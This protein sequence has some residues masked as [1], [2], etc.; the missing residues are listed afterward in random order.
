MEQYVMGIDI[1]TTGAKSMVVALDGKILGAGYCEYPLSYPEPNAV[2][3]SADHMMDKVY[4]TVKDAIKNSGV[5]SARIVAISFSV[6]RATFALLDENYEPIDDRFYVWLDNR[7]EIVMEEIYSKMDRDYMFCITGMPITRTYSVEHLY[8]IKKF[9]PELY[10]KAKHFALVDAYAMWCFGAD[11]FVTETTNAMVSGMMD[12]RTLK[13]NTEVMEALDLRQDLL[14]PLTPPGSVVG[15]VKKFIAER[16]GLTEGTLIIAGS[17]DQQA[18]AMGA[19]VV[20]DGSMSLTLGTIGELVVGLAKPNF[21]ELIN[22]M[23]PST[24][25]LGIFEIEGNQISGA[26]C[27]RWARDVLCTAEVAL[28]EAMGKSTFEIMEEYVNKSVPGSHGVIFQSALFGTGY[29]TQN[30]EASASFV[31]LKP[32]TTRADLV[33]SVMEGITFESRFIYEAIKATGVKTK[34]SITI[35][36]GATKSPAWRQI[37]AD[38]LNCTINTLE[39][40]DASVIGV[41]AL[42]AIGAGIFKS[43]KEGVQRMVRIKDTIKPIPANVAVYDKV[44]PVYRDVYYAFNNNGI[45]TKL[46][47]L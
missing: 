8:W 3:I 47:N 27:Y 33:R 20:E 28:G 6:Q 42:A 45:Y 12:V 32:T 7:P 23:I 19:G 30:G 25:E 39:V 17:G 10:K 18:A 41:A 4:D 2:E 13:W 15:K 14:P 24:P 29:P 37:I 38:V 21:A 34:D 46:Y 44:F 43:T 22:L 5:D 40:P 35:T 11:K 36:G 31:G 26:T 16:T 9:H 1:G